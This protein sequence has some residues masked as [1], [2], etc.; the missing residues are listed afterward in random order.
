MYKEEDHEEGETSGSLK[1]RDLDEDESDEEIVAQAK[2]QK[3]TVNIGHI[4]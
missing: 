3:K 2:I 4:S 1:E